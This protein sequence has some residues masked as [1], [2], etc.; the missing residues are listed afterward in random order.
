MKI[1]LV[2]QE[3]IFISEFPGSTFWLP[4]FL[5]GGK[6]DIKVANLLLA[7]VNLEP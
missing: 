2:F 6:W 3:I 4:T 7:T 5:T 1:G